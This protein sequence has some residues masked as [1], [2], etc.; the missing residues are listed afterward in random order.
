MKRFL[1]D[2]VNTIFAILVLPFLVAG[3]IVILA[4]LMVG[5][6]IYIIIELVE[7][8]VQEHRNY[9]VQTSVSTAI[10]NGSVSITDDIGITNE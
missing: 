7:Y 9:T 10:T 2:A 8:V 4:M 5:S 6:P 1:Y 3:V